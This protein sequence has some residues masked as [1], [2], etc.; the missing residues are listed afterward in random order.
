MHKSEPFVTKVNG[1]EIKS[2][3]NIKPSGAEKKIKRALK[4]MAIRNYREVNIGGKF[5]YD[6]LLPDLNL[7]IEYD[8]VEY[9]DSPSAMI[10]DMEKNKLAK[11]KGFDL[12][13]VTREDYKDFASSIDRFIL[14]RSVH[15]YMEVT[16]ELRKKNDE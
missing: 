11:E 12:L 16:S 15:K 2:Y 3:I 9:H 14:K 7:L 8:S 13:R 10:R 1:V 4:G 6:F 5:R